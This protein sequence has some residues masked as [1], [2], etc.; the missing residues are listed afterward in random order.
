[1]PSA[2]PYLTLLVSVTFA[3]AGHA[4]TLSPSP[5][6]PVARSQQT[7]GLYDLPAPD[8]AP[9]FLLHEPRGLFP[10][11]IGMGV[12]LLTGDRISTQADLHGSDRSGPRLDLSIGLNF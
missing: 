1:M 5:T 11:L 6:A 8:P 3:T 12:G 9:R 7:I 4:E 2:S 10:D